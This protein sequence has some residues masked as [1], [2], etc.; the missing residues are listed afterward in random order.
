MQLQSLFNRVE[1][2][3]TVPHSHTTVRAMSHT[4]VLTKLVTSHTFPRE[5]RCW[6]R[7]ALHKL[8]YYSVREALFEL[9]AQMVCNG[10]RKVCASYKALKICKQDDVPDVTFK[11]TSSV[12]YCARTFSFKN[13]KLSLFSVKGRV[14]VDVQFGKHQADYLALG[15]VKEEELVYKS[16]FWFFNLVLDIPDPKLVKCGAVMGVDVGE[17]NL[18]TTSFGTIHGENRLRHQRDRFLI[19]TRSLQSNGSRSAKRCLQRISGKERRR[20][21]ENNHKVSK[22]I[23]SQASNHGVKLIVLENL[24]NIRK[25]IRGNKRMRSR[26]HRWPWAELQ[27]FI[28][29]KAQGRG[30]EVTYENPAYTS[31]TCSQCGCL[32]EKNRHR[33]CCTSC[34][35]RQH[36]DRNAAVNL[37]KL[38]GSVVPVTA[39]VNGPMVAAFC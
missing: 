37:C 18:A 15:K 14:R 20:V 10:I 33:F 3:L 2:T 32:G 19:S 25:R 36:S 34:G 16:K 8:G 7:V 27:E 17:N 38:A 28:E 26:L 35:S 9:G 21:R 22:E 11:E 39:P 29:Y 30:I 23:V 13:G 6:N 24:T 5:N 4:T 1:R 12:H 31:Q